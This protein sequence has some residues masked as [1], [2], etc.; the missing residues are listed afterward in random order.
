MKKEIYVGNLSFSASAEEVEEI[1]AQFGTV[2]STELIKD[3][4]GVSRGFAFVEMEEKEA[5]AAILGLDGKK[6]KGRNLIVD[7]ARGLRSDG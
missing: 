1:F 5:N 2:Y 7:E 6:H 3:R 4:E